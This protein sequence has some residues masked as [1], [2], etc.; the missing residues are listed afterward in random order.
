MANLGVTIRR[1][2]AAVVLAAGKGTRMKSDRPKVLHTLAGRPMI[3]HVVDTLGRVGLERI[4][5]VVGPGMDSV[6]SAV[7]PHPCVVQKAQLGTGDAVKAAREALTGFSGDVLIVYADAPLVSQATLQRLLAARSAP[8]GPSIAVLGMK[9]SDGGAYGRLVRDAKGGLERIVE[10][11]D[12][13]EAERKINLCN[14]GFMVLDRALL[15]DLLSGVSSANAKNEYYLTDIVKLAR[16]RGLACAAVEGPAAELFGINSR[17]ELAVAETVVQNR[18][19]AAVLG[20]GAT[21]LGPDTVFLSFDTRLGRD[22]TVG[23]FVVFGPDVVVE[24]GAEIRAFCHIERARIGKVAVIGPFARLRPGADIGEAAHVGNFVEIKNAVLAH[25]AKANHLSYIGDA[26]VGADANIGAGTIT[27]NYD[28]FAKAITEIGDGAFIGSNTSLVAP[29]RIG[30][31]AIIGAGSVITRDVDADALAI[32]RG[33]QTTLAG[34]AK[35]YR[36]RK[37]GGSP[38]QSAGKSAA[39]KKKN[40]KPGK[41]GKSAGRARPKTRRGR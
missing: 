21:L 1:S 5:V 31:G 8:P 32:A 35:R 28:G 3:G 29:V 37:G 41:P 26:K 6:A 2:T 23:P 13:T 30:A 36:E 9:L 19:R 25:G 14:S 40:S 38:K 20:G 18:L 15:F 7:A 27:C 17:T 11:R 10:A 4:V 39:G 22:V 34:G 33:E 12:A 24:D 16:E